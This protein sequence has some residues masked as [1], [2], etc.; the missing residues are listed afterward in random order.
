MFV[1]VFTVANGDQIAEHGYQYRENVPLSE[2]FYNTGK[3]LG[4]IHALSKKYEATHKRFD[5]FDKYNEQYFEELLPN[6]FT[7]LKNSLSSHLEKLRNLPKTKENYGMVHFDFSDGNYNIDYDTGKITV[8]DF[9]NCRT[10]FY[11]F[12]LANL[13]THGV[14]WIAY[15]KDIQKRKTFMEEYFETILQGYKSETQISDEELDLL[16]LMIQTV[17]MENIIDEFEVQENETG[18]FEHDE[19]IDFLIDCM[20]HNIEY[21]GFFADETEQ[22][23]DK[24]EIVT[25]DDLLFIVDLLSQ[26]NIKY[27]LVGGWGIDVLVGKQNR[28]H[29]DIDINF[30]QNDTEKLLQI[31][32]DAGYKIE[33]DIRPIRIELHSEKYGYID[34]HPFV[35]NADGSAKKSDTQGGWWIFEK[36]YFTTVNFANKKMPCLSVKGQKAFHSGYTPREKDEFDLEL[37]NCK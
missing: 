3:T 37:L 15:E 7:E 34:I 18:T 9:E 30:D 2:Y 1:S 10:C 21:M 25:Q 26:N 20:I 36:D 29:R 23:E 6:E 16:P 31:L 13:W 32:Q 8:F 17:L 14:G 12:D 4:K 27:Y 33:T 28:I 24:K 22:I 19:E 11:L 35:I 5:F